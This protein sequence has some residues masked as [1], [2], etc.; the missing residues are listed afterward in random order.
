MPTK[1]T[2]DEATERLEE[3]VDRAVAGEE[4]WIIAPDGMVFWLKPLVAPDGT[5]LP[6]T[7]A[8]ANPRQG[9]SH[10]RNR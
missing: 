3:L 5:P 4:I 1:F 2:A 10:P 7:E 6:H 9:T 8:L